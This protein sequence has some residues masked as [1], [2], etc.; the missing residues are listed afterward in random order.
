M[1]TYHLACAA[2][3]ALIVT[4]AASQNGPPLR[5]LPETV[6]TATR[7]P[8]PIAR[9]PA[10]VTVIDRETIERRGYRSLAEALAAVPGLRAVQSGGTG[11]QTSLFVR[12]TNSSHVLVLRDGMPLNDPSTPQGLFDF[13][14]DLLSDVERIEVIRGPMSGL[15]GSGAIGGV[16]NLITRSGRGTG[17]AF[18][19]TGELAGG[20]QSTAAATGVIAGEAHGLDYALIGE[21]FTTQ[22]FNVKPRR[23]ATSIGER[24]GARIG[25]VT[26]NLGARL[27]ERFR[28]FGFGRLRETR[29]DLDQAGRDDPNYTLRNRTGMWRAGIAGALIPG[30]LDTTLAVGQSRDNRQFRDRPD[31][32]AFSGSDD[33]RYIGTRT[34]WQWDNTLRLPDL[35]VADAASVTFGLQRI[36]DRADVQV[37]FDGPFG[38]FGQDVDRGTRN[39]AA[40]LGGQM[41]LFRRLDLTA[42]LRHERPRAFADTTTWRVGGVLAIPE[43]ALSVHAAYGTSFRAPTLFDLFGVGSFGFRGNPDL[44]PER[45]RG[46]EAGVAFDLA[47]L[48]LP[49][50]RLS[51][52]WFRTRITDLI[53][54][55]PSF[56]TRINVGKA[57]IEGVETALDVTV[58]P[59]LALR[60]GYT[61]TVAQDGD[62]GLQLLRRPRH[63]GSLGATIQADPRFSIT[64]E[65]LL[66]GPTADVIYADSGAFLGRGR[67]PGG[68]VVNLT[69]RWRATETVELFALG[70]NITNSRYEPA[71]AFVVPGAA[72]LVGVRAGL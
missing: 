53:A 65:V 71:N 56:T 48:G 24:D 70:R 43:A 35:G 44:R 7:V 14:N 15:Y 54:D 16:V 64:P 32:F 67:N 36:E 19:A 18:T 38:P 8:T 33:S 37:R 51:A 40:Y 59:W 47:A 63:Q 5:T 21:G 20:S 2:A 3:A 31:Q 22:G 25:A 39:D 49:P 46:G 72:V 55:D 17:R 45:G 68:V 60:A 58:A 57:N 52:T 23:L 28:V 27:G 9:I 34:V 29:A 10:G 61:W 11:Q 62:T 30:L 6:V 42:A 69:A 4:P 50:G 1:R 41:R 13:G 66:F 12:G 26:L